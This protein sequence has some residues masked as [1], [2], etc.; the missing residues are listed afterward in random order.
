MDLRGDLKTIRNGVFGTSHSIGSSDGSIEIQPD[1]GCHKGCSSDQCAVCLE[2]QCNTLLL[3]CSH[4]FHAQCIIQWTE[5]QFSCPLCRSEITHF[6]PLR[7]CKKHEIDFARIWENH[8]ITKLLRN[9][10]A[11]AEG[12]SQAPTNEQP[13]QPVGSPRLVHIVQNP[14]DL[15]PTAQPIQPLPTRPP[16]VD[17]IPIPVHY[18]E[19]CQEKQIPR[20]PKKPDVLTKNKPVQRTSSLK[21]T[22]SLRTLLVPTETMKCYECSALIKNEFVYF[23]FDHKFCSTPCRLK[24]ARGS[25]NGRSRR[26]DDEGTNK[27]YVDHSQIAKYLI[28]RNGTSPIEVTH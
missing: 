1:F 28:P 16:V 18:I 8:Y 27:F 5:R 22:P 25:R 21:R 20:P 7:D 12:G 19:S 23:A 24:F 26:V 10:A 14:E 3:P 15:A 11:S 4:Q 6:V 17:N 2:K 13:T 9:L